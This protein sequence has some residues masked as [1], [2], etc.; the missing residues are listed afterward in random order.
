MSRIQLEHTRQQLLQ[1]FR[2]VFFTVRFVLAMSSPEDI[3]PIASNAFVIW[4]SGLGSG[5]RWV[6]RDHDEKYH[7][8]GKEIGLLSVVWSVKMD[9][10]SHI[11]KGT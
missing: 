4:V 10:R 7:S 3:S 9:F 1:L 11:V 8:C 2:K 5:E 6:L